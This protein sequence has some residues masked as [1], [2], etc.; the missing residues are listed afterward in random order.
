MKKLIV[1]IL[2]L[3]GFYGFSQNTKP[4][5]KTIQLSGILISEDSLKAV[6][7]A[8]IK[9]TKTDSIDYSYFFSVPTDE[10]GYFVLMARPGD[11]ISFKKEGFMDTNYTIPDTLKAAKYSITQQIKYKPATKK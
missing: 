1:T 3:I 5:K 11:I 9:I 10:N 2:L 8:S 7:G 6:K 4:I